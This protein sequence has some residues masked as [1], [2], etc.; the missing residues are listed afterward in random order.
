MST[1]SRLA[2]AVSALALAA[3]FAAG[4]GRKRD[5]SAHF[6]EP[7]TD[8]PRT[9][10]DELLAAPD[11]FHRKTVR[12]VGTIERQC[13]MSGCWFVLDDGRGHELKAELGDYHPKLPPNI[14]NQAEVEG[15]LVRRGSAYELIG[16]RVTFTAKEKAP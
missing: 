4:C 5:A 14:G 7:F 16:T 1:T 15:E 3:L 9:A 13:P 6:G 12:V 8:A 10:I 11:S 2:V